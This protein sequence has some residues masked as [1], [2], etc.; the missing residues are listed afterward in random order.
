MSNK[1]IRHRTISN[2]EGRLVALGCED[3]DQ[4]YTDQCRPD[5]YCKIASENAV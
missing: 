4:A 1:R 3:E 5:T 2:L